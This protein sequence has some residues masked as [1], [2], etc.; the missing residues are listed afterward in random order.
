VLVRHLSPA[1]S[2]PLDDPAHD[3]VVTWSSCAASRITT[4]S[5]ASIHVYDC[6]RC[7]ERNAAKMCL[8]YHTNKGSVISVFSESV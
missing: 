5:E 6:P 2:V 7:S 3:S 4:S 8:G 1:G